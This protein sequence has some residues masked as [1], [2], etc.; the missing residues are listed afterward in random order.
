M[1]LVER[2]LLS[3]FILGISGLRY[4]LYPIHTNLTCL[5]KMGLPKKNQS[6]KVELAIT[7]DSGKF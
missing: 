2:R 5:I 3:I 7:L 1:S 4:I 6:K